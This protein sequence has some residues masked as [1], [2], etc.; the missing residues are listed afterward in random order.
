MKLRLEIPATICFTVEGDTEE[1]IVAEGN[2]LAQE[3]FSEGVYLY[4]DG[5]EGSRLYVSDADSAE[6]IDDESDDDED[7]VE[8]PAVV[9]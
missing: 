7:E 3:Q 5:V 1:A 4:F 8:E 9:A 2:K 6:V